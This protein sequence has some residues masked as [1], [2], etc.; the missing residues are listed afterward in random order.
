MAKKIRFPLQMNG[1][2]V[3]TIEELRENFDLSSILGY[4]TNGKLVTWLEDRYYDNEA[5]AVRALSTDEAD[6]NQKLMSILGVSNDVKTEEIDLE[7]IQRRNEKLMLLRQITDDKEIIDNVDCVAFN[8][9]EL[10]D[11]LDD[12]KE[13]IYLCQGE[14]NIPL[15]VKNVMYIGLDDPIVFL[16][17]YDNVNFD[18]QNIKFIN[19]CFGWDI[20][21][22]TNKDRLYQAERLMEQSKFKEAISI[23]EILTAEKNPRAFTMLALIYEKVYENNDKSQKIKI[24]SAELGNVFDWVEIDKE[25]SKYKELLHKMVNK[26]DKIAMG[27]LGYIYSLDND[28][29]NASHFFELGVSKKDMLSCEALYSMYMDEYMGK[30]IPEKYINK[31]KAL[32]YGKEAAS[33]GVAEI[34][35]KVGVV[36]DNGKIV[37]RDIDRAIKYYKIAASYGN[38]FAYNNLGLCYYN[39]DGVEQDYKKAAELFSKAA[40]QGHSDAQNYLGLCYY[41]GYGVEQN[42]NVA[43]HWFELAASNGHEIAK[44]NADEARKRIRESSRLLSDSDLQEL[45]KNDEN[46]RNK[47]QK[48]F[49]E[50][51]DEL[52]SIKD[53]LRSEGFFDILR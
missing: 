13:T 20:S 41:S 30:D 7:A 26:G 9:D 32:T 38:T 25:F 22:I 6:L 8:Q 24:Q 42:Y 47:S 43:L 12:G 21:N 5:M 3:R 16:R 46:M 2:D 49:Q 50:L 18:S 29:D 34:A 48:I 52:S 53:E 51:H 44:E 36:Y 40:K 11:I 37:S 28:F 10:Y 45:K 15:T 27:Y 1:T 4:L 31:I 23:L 17:A 14:F 19:I 39:G 33:L 35:N